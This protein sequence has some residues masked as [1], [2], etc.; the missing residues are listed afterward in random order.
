[1]AIAGYYAK[2]AGSEVYLLVELNGP[3]NAVW[4]EI[5]S[6]RRHMF[7]G[8][9]PREMEERGLADIFANVRNYL[10][11]RPDSLSQGKALHWK[12]SGGG[13]PTSKVRVME[14]LRD[15]TDNGMLKI[16]S[17]ET[18]KEMR[19]VTREGDSIAAQGHSKD[20]RVMALALGIRCWEERVRRT[21]SVGQRTRERELAK[22]RLSPEDKYKMF[23]SFQFQ[24]FLGAKEMIRE[25]E[26]KALRLAQRRFGIRR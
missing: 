22:V 24:K 13:G 4:D 19:S 2:P 11:S 14:R 3:G 18:L 7:A 17:M 15:F 20:D 1:M 12:T 25:R 6:T 23:T 26:N 8:Y 16:R 21:M 10:Y 9:Q 5:D